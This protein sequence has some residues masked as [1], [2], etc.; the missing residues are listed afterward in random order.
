MAIHPRV[1]GSSALIA[2]LVNI[3]FAH[4][5]IIQIGSILRDAAGFVPKIN[6]ASALLFDP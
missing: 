4:E 6:N 2:K 5:R 1:G 3:L